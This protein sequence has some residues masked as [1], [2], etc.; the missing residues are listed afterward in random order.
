MLYLDL[1]R[2]TMET[3]LYHDNNNCRFQIDKY[4]Y[5]N[6]HI[7]LAI[8]L[9]TSFGPVEVVMLSLWGYALHISRL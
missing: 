9:A 2:H 4:G 5:R 3:H 1:E 8:D 7:W 6:Y